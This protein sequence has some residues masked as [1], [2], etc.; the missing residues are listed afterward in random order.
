MAAKIEQVKPAFLF[1]LVQE[2]SNTLADCLSSDEQETSVSLPLSQPRFS[3]NSFG[4]E[5]KETVRKNLVCI[6]KII[7]FRNNTQTTAL[8]IFYHN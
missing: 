1:D 7:F 8:L 5:K 2:L 4:A 3:T 6:L